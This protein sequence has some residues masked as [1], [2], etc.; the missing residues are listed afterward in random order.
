MGEYR[1][2]LVG[3]S[4]YQAAVKAAWVGQR[5]ELQHEP[6][7]RFDRRAIRAST[8]AGT[9]GYVARDSWLHSVLIDEGKDVFARVLEVTG[10]GRGQMRGIVLTVWT[11]PDAEVARQTKVLP[12]PGCALLLVVLALVCLLP[13]AGAWASGPNFSRARAD[14]AA[15]C[16]SIKGGS[17]C[18]ERQ[19]RELGHFV[20]MMAAFRFERAELA[21]CMAKAKRGRFIDWTVATPCLRVKARGRAIGG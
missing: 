18:V 9:I 14:N 7:N 5:V 11:G 4:K 20:T 13:Y 8:P 2:G 15:Y 3:E 10:G 6:G 16:R 1:L 19:N 17:G 21:G 12:K